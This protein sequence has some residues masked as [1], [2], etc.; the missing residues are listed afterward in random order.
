MKFQHRLFLTL[1]VPVILLLAAFSWL[2]PPDP[3]DLGAVLAWLALGPG[4]VYVAGQAFSYLLE[5]VPGWGTTVPEGARPY[6]V[7]AI[8]VG[9]AAGAN[10]LLTRADV[11]GA[12]GPYYALIFQI[13]A[14]WLGTQKAFSDQ[15]ARGLIQRPHKA[16]A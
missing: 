6:I 14:A 9:L 4:A 13:I 11:V 12:I 10:F 5:K 3:S 8:A 2:Q 16:P 7:L 1:L 15:K